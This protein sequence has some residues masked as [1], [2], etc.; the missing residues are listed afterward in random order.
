MGLLRAGGPVSNPACG[1]ASLKHLQNLLTAETID[2]WFG[3]KG[4]MIVIRE[5]RTQIDTAQRNLAVAEQA[6]ETREVYLH[7][8]RLRYLI[9]IATRHGIDVTAWI[10]PSLLDPAMLVPSSSSA[11]EPSSPLLGVL[12]RLN[13]PA[14]QRTAHRTEQ[15]GSVASGSEQARSAT[16][17]GAEDSSRQPSALD[18]VIAVASARCWT[19]SPPPRAHRPR[20]EARPTPPRSRDPS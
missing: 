5:L 10:D 3:W 13:P 11:T 1:I 18:P 16:P 12:A 14:A 17:F 15:A 4:L 2:W 6:G 7:Q 8:A 19:Q 20:R 9:D